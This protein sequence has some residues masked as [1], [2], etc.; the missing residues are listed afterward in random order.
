MIRETLL[1][2]YY[3]N[4]TQVPHMPALCSLHPELLTS[5]AKEPEFALQNLKNLEQNS[6]VS[7]TMSNEKAEVED[8]PDKALKFTKQKSSKIEEVFEV[9]TREVRHMSEI[10]RPNLVDLRRALPPGFDESQFEHES[11][12]RARANTA[13]NPMRCF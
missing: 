4:P 12:A 8:F 3:Q 11:V 6:S 5:Q 7:T 10:A 9:R 1:A 2:V 13:P